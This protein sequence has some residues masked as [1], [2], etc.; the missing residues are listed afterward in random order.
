MKKIFGVVISLSFLATIVF[1]SCKR[2]MS[3]EGCAGNNKPPVA[4][5]GI[6]QTIT[7]QK[8]SVLLDGSASSDPDGTITKYRWTKISGPVS[9]IIVSAD[10]AKTILRS[11]IVGVYNFELIVTDNGGLSAKDTV[12][13]TV[14]DSPVNHP[15]IARAGA[16][17]TIILP[18]N[19]VT[20]DGSGSSD[21]DN[22]ITTYLWTKISG[23]SSFTI[24]N[25]NNVKTMVS[26]LVQG[27]YAFELKVTDAG[28]LFSKDTVEVKVNADLSTA[29]DPG[30]RPL[31][32][33]QMIP[34][35]QGWFGDLVAGV[36]SKLFFLSNRGT[37]HGEYTEVNIY[38]VCTHSLITKPLGSPRGRIAVTTLGSK[39][40][41]AGGT[42]EEDVILY[43]IYADVD[44]YDAATNTWSAVFL[45]KPKFDL[46]AGGVG[47]KVLFAGG[48]IGSAGYQ[49]E[50]EILDLSSN[51]WSLASLSEGRIYSS[52]VSTNSRVYFAGGVNYPGNVS[53]KIDIFDSTSNTWYVSNL[54]EPKLWMA[55]AV[56]G[57]KIFWAG[58]FPS[59]ADNLFPSS[60]VQIQD[61]QTGNSIT[62]CLFQP[63]GD[64]TAA[65]KDDK[66]VFFTS[67]SAA[68]RN[69]FDVYDFTAR[70][71]LIG[72][73]QDSIVGKIIS[74]NNEI[75]VA[76]FVYDNGSASNPSIWKLVF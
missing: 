51:T 76:G 14:A 19:T 7:L 4:N 52:V 10:S 37:V 62:T 55:S 46:M 40:F 28:G 39:V 42:L 59:L 11:L 18:T 24:A 23:P 41:F 43:A 69:K 65:I 60:N 5:A 1:L 33:V 47:N 6:D 45:S 32:Q 15:P 13:I 21:P 73:M 26:N 31:V 20:L 57:G 27:V 30:A 29:C 75:Y 64:F 8:D 12:Q 36:G 48:S 71:W 54:N 2:E 25:A 9:S 74:L 3:C 44:I 53:D 56:L 72:V 16:D 50:V 67:E 38:D 70:S 58:G 68:I 49:S 22:N 17:Q 34:I 35:A 66:I 63:N 61:V